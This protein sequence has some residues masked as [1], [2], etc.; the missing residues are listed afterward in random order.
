MRITFALLLSSAALAQTPSIQWNRQFGTPGQGDEARSAAPAPGPGGGVYAAGS[1]L[2]DL[3]GFVNAGFYDAFVRKYDAAG[4][5]LWTRQF[6]TAGYDFAYGVA[7][8]DSGVYVAGYTGGALSDQTNAGSV[9]VFLR[10][11]DHDGNEVWTRQFGTASGDGAYGIAVNEQGVFVVGWTDGALPGEASAGSTDAFVRMYDHAGNAVWTRQF[12]STGL[13]QDFA[14]AVAVDASGVYVAGF[15]S[16]GALPGESNAGANDAFV[17]KYDFSGNALWTRQFGSTANDEA[18]GVAA[19]STG[20]V[21]AGRTVGVLPGEASEGAYDAF[22]RKYDASGNL[23]WTRQFGT[24]SDDMAFAAAADG[25]GNVY[26][27]GFTRGGRFADSSISGFGFVRKYDDGGG[28]LWTFQ[29][30]T[31]SNTYALGAAAHAAGVYVAGIGTGNAGD[32][33]ANVV[34]IADSTNQP[35]ALAAASA[36][37]TVNEG[38]VAVNSGTYSDPDAGDNV[39]ISASFGAI[40]KTG[41]NAGNW[42]WSWNAMDGPA[43]AQTVTITASD[44]NGVVVSTSFTVVVS[45]VAPTLAFSVTPVLTENQAVTLTGVIVDPGTLDS[46]AVTINWGDGATSTLLLSAG[47]LGFTATHTYLDDNPSGTASDNYTV[48]VGVT[49]KDNGSAA[50]S[51]TVVV[52]NAA[53]SIGAASGPAS[54]LIL[55][56]A[57]TVAA[58][59]SDPGPADTLLCTYA[60]GDG[61]DNTTAAPAGGS[62]SASHTYAVPG[63]YGV[64]I[65]VTDDDTGASSTRFEYVVVYDPAGG[66]VTGGGSIQSPPGAYSDNPSLT[67]KA[68]FGFVSRYKQGAAVPDG[69]TQFKF[70]AA[71]LDFHSASYE[72]LVVAG[73]RAQFKGTGR[74]NGAGNYG[75]LLTAIDGQVS[76]G[77]GLDRLRMKIW[78]IGSGRVVYDNQPG[79]PDSGDDA[80]ELAGGSIVI[81]KP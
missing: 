76:G 56:E 2:G 67:G 3:P 41:A 20:V 33:D 24:S 51:A 28:R 18:Y 6:G 26:V 31:A 4:N 40:S 9:D 70:H 66:F 32:T 44:G 8:D 55:G 21:V 15:A 49:D 38:G 57:V 78:D 54:P 42:T 48:A 22:A 53:P 13:Y 11:Y 52:N 16:Y 59:V 72:W 62:C 69:Q 47:E 34:K 14:R 36:L 35:P 17:R 39:V 27:A 19:G 1:T 71:S 74:I 58:A 43:P 81:H 45:N 79:A 30:G 68:T 25:F 65:T 60:W 10:K 63:V 7:A 64:L 46:H 29:Y 5:E 37:V 50:A 75:F 61:T 80:T 23:V 77:G 12:G 73:A